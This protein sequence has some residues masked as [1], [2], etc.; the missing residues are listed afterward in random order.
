MIAID[1]LLNPTYLYPWRNDV[2]V[3]PSPGS[4]AMNSLAG[5][6]DLM[7]GRAQRAAARPADLTVNRYG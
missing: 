6:P 7:G 4:A 3:P 5:A 1:L 2:T